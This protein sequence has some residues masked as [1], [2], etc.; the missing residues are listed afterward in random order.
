MTN[1]KMT[2]CLN[3]H[4]LQIKTIES[5]KLFFELQRIPIENSFVKE[6]LLRISE[7]NVEFQKFV[8]ESITH[9]LKLSCNAEDL[10]IFVKRCE[11]DKI[12]NQELLDYLKPLLI[13]TK[14]LQEESI[15]LR[16][17]ITRIKECLDKIINEIY[18]EN[19]KI[20]KR[21]EDLPEQINRASNMIDEAISYA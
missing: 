18:E 16:E 12:N 1:T 10:I 4:V 14:L 17:Q 6:K 13:D 20:T 7:Q 21:R 2:K 15:K 9:S 8:K 19:F 3:I 5:I 11:D